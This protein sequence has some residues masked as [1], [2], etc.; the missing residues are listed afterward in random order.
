MAVE[1]AVEINSLDQEFTDAQMIAASLGGADLLDT[2]VDIDLEEKL[3]LLNEIGEIQR[4][5]AVLKKVAR[6]LLKSNTALED[7]HREMEE[8]SE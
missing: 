8:L 4:A 6:T 7:D 3:K 1:L 2:K 5:D